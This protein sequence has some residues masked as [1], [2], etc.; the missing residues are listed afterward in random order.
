MNHAE[1]VAIKL[2]ELEGKGWAIERVDGLAFTFEA[3][4]GAT[5]ERCTKA[6]EWEAYVHAVS[7]AALLQGLEEELAE[8][9]AARLYDHENDLRTE[10]VC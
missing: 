1:Q 9:A 5:F 8:A 4:K 7:V 3:R 6:D 2:T 10:E